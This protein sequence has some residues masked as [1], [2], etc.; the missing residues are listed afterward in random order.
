MADVPRS[1]AP[2]VL[3]SQPPAAHYDES[4]TPHDT[5][6]AYLRGIC[7]QEKWR[8]QHRIGGSIDVPVCNDHML[9]TRAVQVSC[10]FTPACIYRSA[11]PPCLRCL[12]CARSPGLRTVTEELQSAIHLL[13]LE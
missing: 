4:Q 12:R 3:V 13:A 6:W 1:L 10:S 2:L 8:E 11:L 5:V 7:R 9:I